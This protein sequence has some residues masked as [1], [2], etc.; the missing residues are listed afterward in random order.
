MEY[1]HLDDAINYNRLST[2]NKAIKFWL[3]VLKTY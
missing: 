2:Q 3:Y 1:P